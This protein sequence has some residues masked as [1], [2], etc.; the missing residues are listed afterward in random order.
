MLTLYTLE[1]YTMRFMKVLYSKA[2]TK[3]DTKDI[4][5]LRTTPQ[6]TYVFLFLLQAKSLAFLRGLYQL[7][8][9]TK[10]LRC[11]QPFQQRNRKFR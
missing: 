4:C 10:Q 9:I 7:L 2:T 8:Q 3:Q 5:T 11:Y 6:Y 1:G